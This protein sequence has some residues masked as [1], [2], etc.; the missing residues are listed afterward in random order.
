MK[1]PQDKTKWVVDPYAAAIVQRIFALSIE[2]KGPL[3]IAKILEAD[4]IE[5]PGAYL[6]KQGLGTFKSRV[7][8][9]PCCWSSTTVANIIEK[10][11]YL[12]HTVNF[13]TKKESFKDK[14]QTWN[15]KEDWLIFENTHKA[16]VDAET[17]QT[18]QRVRKTK[19]RT[20]TTGEPNPLTGILHCADCGRRMHN[21][22]RPAYEKTCNETGK[23]RRISAKDH[24]LCPTYNTRGPMR[25]EGCSAHYITSNAANALLLETIKRTT[26][27]AR[28]NEDEFVEMLREA[29]EIKQADAAKTHKQ[30]IAK[31]ERRIAELDLLFR[32]TYEDFV[33]GRLTEKRF[34]LLSSGYET[35][36]ADLQE[37]T[38][39]LKAELTQ[40]DD[41]SVRAD[42]FMELVRRYT[43][44]AELTPA[45]LHEFVEKVV[46]HE[47]DKSSGRRQQ[48]VDIYLNFIGQFNVPDDDAHEEEFDEQ[49]RAK[50]REYK[51][52]Q[53]Q[54]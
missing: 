22:R 39:K 42:K 20:D 43:D 40:F 44:F 54:K 38:A 35:E 47:S 51:R 1:D 6:A 46:V 19:R 16:I 26:T 3:Q 53:R 23:T 27:F 5:T 48:R 8:K 37:Q 13:R 45:M 18:A 33:A 14:T 52:Q 28:S 7:F 2:G 4:G 31:N 36:Q 15:S 12:G 9:H 25:D 10:P 34:E 30:S 29:A 49:Q 21:H 17:W 41:D 32:K 11:E 50:W 24:Y